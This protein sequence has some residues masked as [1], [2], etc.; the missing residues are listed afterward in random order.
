MRRTEDGSG[1]VFMGL[2]F[3]SDSVYSGHERGRAR[4]RVGIAAVVAAFLV[5]FLRAVS[6]HVPAPTSNA[7]AGTTVANMIWERLLNCPPLSLPFAEAATVLDVNAEVDEVSEL[8]LA[9]G[10]GLVLDTEVS[11]DVPDAEVVVDAVKRVYPS[12]A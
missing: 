7:S 6:H 10:T 1:L 12:A 9:F 2:A 11:D 8:L 3:L 5:L 4:E